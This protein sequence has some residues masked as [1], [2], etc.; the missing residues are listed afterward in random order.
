MKYLKWVFFL[1]LNLVLLAVL[2]EEYSFSPEDALEVPHVLLFG[3]FFALNILF[4]LRQYLQYFVE[5]DSLEFK[6]IKIT[7][8]MFVIVGVLL[9]GAYF[10][11]HTFWPLAG[12]FFLEYALCIFVLKQ[13]KRMKTKRDSS[14][15][16]SESLSAQAD[17]SSE[18][19]QSR[20]S[21]KG[22]R[23]T[24]SPVSHCEGVPGERGRRKVWF[25]IFLGLTVLLILLSIRMSRFALQ[26][27][28]GNLYMDMMESG[29]GAAI[30]KQ[31]AL[32]I[33][34]ISQIFY[35]FG[36]PFP[37]YL[38]A[39]LLVAFFLGIQIKSRVLPLWKTMAAVCVFGGAFL[40]LFFSTWRKTPLIENIVGSF[41]I[42]LGIF[43]VFS[44]VIGVG[45]ISARRV[46]K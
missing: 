32:R 34:H 35:F 7:P 45:K 14:V 11:K 18:V 1:G 37:V 12:L 16:S 30:A 27:S 21:E 15:P 13:I 8:S 19:E 9:L 5:K 23:A 25:K 38:L 29:V 44:L 10:L 22:R 42:W 46:G 28:S 17:S 40:S 20:D 39:N 36:F 33:G 24:D 31:E 26:V 41:M 4:L 6:D 43:L 3:A 2:V